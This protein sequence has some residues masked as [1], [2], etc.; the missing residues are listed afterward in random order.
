MQPIRFIL[1]IGLVAGLLPPLWAQVATQSSSHWANELARQTDST[2][3]A[4]VLLFMAKDIEISDPKT[5]LTYAQQAFNLGE[6][7][8]ASKV[9]GLAALQLSKLHAILGNKAKA[10]RFRKRAEE[11]L[12]SVD[13]MAELNQLETQKSQAE[14]AARANADAAAI[15]QQAVNQ[16]SGEA[17]QKQV[18]LAQ[19]GKQ[20]SLRNQQLRQQDKLIGQKNQLIGQKNQLIGQKDSMLTKR[21]LILQSQ[22]DQI[23]ILEQEKA[24]QKAEAE[25]ER[26]VRNALL[27]GAGLLLALAGL[28][29]R[30]ITNKQRTNRELAQKN[31]QLD[32]ARQRSDE[33]LL[34][35][36][37]S[38][39][40]DE[41]KVKG[42][43]R[44]RQHE[45][46]TIMFT[47]FRDF[48]KISEQLSPTDLVQE[49]DYCFRHFD[50][51]IG[52]YPSLEK[53]KTIGDAYLCAGGLPAAHPDHAHDMVAAAL[54]IRD[55]VSELEKQRAREGKVAFQ[56][57]IGIHTGPVIAGVVGATK[58]A[59]DIWGDTV[60]TAA[61]L[62]SASEPG[63]VNISGAT[64]QRIQD[65]FTCRYRG[66]IATKNKANMN[67]YFVDK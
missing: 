46:V 33:L 44:T 21:E 34:N 2:R 65:Q 49:I 51:I 13:L 42:I 62:E 47:D 26:T 30:L 8:K 48:T 66:E 25:H 57:R 3:K 31:T 7:L 38:E 1:L 35:I 40:V 64:Y 18:I 60:N 27:A 41:L 24:L 14:E 32:L 9:I 61:R 17:Q 6:Q 5:A 36:L 23:K 52:K 29:W 53:I 56:I 22:Q 67:M 15:S 39:L 4:E 20:L 10:R 55:F 59:Y 54:D 11:T 45:E 19:Q 50:H 43:T 16:L 63:Q 37:P 28:L 12:R 58:F